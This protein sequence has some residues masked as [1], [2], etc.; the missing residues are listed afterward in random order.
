LL[1]NV[2]N[3]HVLEFHNKECIFKAGD[4]AD[5]VYMV[6]QGK[7]KLLIPQKNNDNFSVLILNKGHLFGELGVMNDSSRA[8]TAI[9][10]GDLRLL[11]ID[12]SE[13]M[14][15][16]SISS[17]F[18][19]KIERLQRLYE[20]PLRGTVEQYTWFL[21]EVGNAI[22]NIYKL[23]DGTEVNS[24]KMLD[25]D[26]FSMRSMEVPQ[27]K[28]FHYDKGDDHV[29]IVVH[30]HHLIGIKANSS[31]NALPELCYMLLDKVQIKDEDVELFKTTGQLKE[32]V[33]S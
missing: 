32:P 21:P 1:S 3:P 25:N 7:V 8:A 20:L 22:M 15:D 12:G 13:F 11:A 2:E 16:I 29:E 14:K 18:K 6:I 30:E 17:S 4:K 9:A 10:D 5:S 33:I 31:F 24:I 23:E 28:H 26:Q 19:L 27:A